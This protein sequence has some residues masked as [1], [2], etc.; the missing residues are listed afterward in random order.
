MKSIRCLNSA[1]CS[2]TRKCERDLT[3]VQWANVRRKHN[4]AHTSYVTERSAAALIES[5]IT[6]R[7]GNRTR[8]RLLPCVSIHYATHEP[9]TQRIYIIIRPYVCTST[10]IRTTNYTGQWKLITYGRPLCL[11]FQ[12]IYISESTHSTHTG[13]RAL[14]G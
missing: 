11:R 5:R 7:L 2:S 14:N 6:H 4:V 13:P 12:N 3:L 1:L 9:E 8:K 10:S